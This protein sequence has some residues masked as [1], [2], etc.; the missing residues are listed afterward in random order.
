MT[1]L[2]DV[3]RALSGLLTIAV[4]LGLTVMHALT[5]IE[6]ASSERLILLGVAYSLLGMDSLIAAFLKAIQRIDLSVKRDVDGE[7]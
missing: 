6:F 3:T 5:M 4:F 7:E 1:R 2:L